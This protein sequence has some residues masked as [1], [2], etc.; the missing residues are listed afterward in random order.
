LSEF[1]GER[2]IPGKVDIDL[3]NEHLARYT[4]AARLAPGKRVLDAG[5]GAGYGS[6]ELAQHARSVVGADCAPEAV[7]FARAHYRLGNLWFEQASCDALPHADGS[8]DLVVA[9][10]VLEHLANW[11]D[12]LREARRVLTPNG[13]LAISTPNKLYYTESRGTHGANPFHVHEF[14]FVEFQEE[15]RSLFPHVSLFLEN[16]VESVTFQPQEAGHTVEVR[17]DAGEP[18]PDDSHFFVAVCAGRPQIGNPTF[19]YVP[20]TAN[21]LRERER[22]ILLL[23]RELAEKDGWLAEAQHDLEEMT[24]Q[25]AKLEGELE[26]SNRWSQ[27][28][29]TELEARR[30]RVADLQD[31]LAREQENARQVFAGLREEI[32]NEQENTRQIAGVYEAKIGELEDEL[33]REQENARQMAAGYEAKVHELEED[34][35]SKIE[36]ALRVEKNL[37]AEIQK[38]TAELLKAVEALNHTEN[39]LQDRTRWA[40]RLQEEASQLAQQVELFRASR[41]VRM[42]RKVGLGP[43]GA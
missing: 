30:A 34:I 43:P 16:H 9:F 39:E 8:F 17:V 2:V 3:L 18:A 4:F 21:V 25:Y 26:E 7:D 42:G 20:R 12:F 15:L 22:H 37:T 27:T 41:W 24:G 38:Q 29:N 5:C 33:T 28:L 40:L 35:R 23:E 31:E 6:A 13:Q 11:R 19:V 32:A 10:E 36:W 14:S 1:T